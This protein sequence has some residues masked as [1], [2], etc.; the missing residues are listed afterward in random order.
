MNVRVEFL[1]CNEEFVFNVP[2]LERSCS[3]LLQGGSSPTLIL[4]VLAVVV[5]LDIP[6]PDLHNENPISFH[7]LN[8]PRRSY[9]S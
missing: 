1:V 6:S 4:Q 7:S 5:L 8:Q 9:S 3:L 2:Q